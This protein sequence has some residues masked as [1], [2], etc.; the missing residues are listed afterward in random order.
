MRMQSR[1]RGLD[2]VLVGTAGCNNT[3]EIW[4]H[5]KVSMITGDSNSFM[6]VM[7]TP[8]QPIMLVVASYVGVKSFINW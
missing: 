4:H 5:G 8:G 2:V 3:D 1:Q 6:D 7:Y